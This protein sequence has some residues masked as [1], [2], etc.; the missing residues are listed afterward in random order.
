MKTFRQFL[1]ENTSIEKQHWFT[2]YGYGIS[3]KAIP[4]KV[5]EQ[6]KEYE[7]HLKAGY[8]AGILARGQ[9]TSKPPKN[10]K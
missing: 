5:P 9:K 7:E 6:S 1:K 10:K 8:E 4:K 2:G 3:G